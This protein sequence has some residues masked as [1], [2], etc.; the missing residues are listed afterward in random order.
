MSFNHQT[1]AIRSLFKKNSISKFRNP[2]SAAIYVI[3]N[4]C[5]LFVTYKRLA[6]DLGMDLFGI[7]AL[8][9]TLNVSFS[10]FLTGFNGSLI[11]F[12]PEFESKNNVS[13]VNRF[14]TTTVWSVI[15]I[16]TIIL[17]A[18][19][20]LPEHII[21]ILFAKEYYGVIQSSFPLI[22][23]YIWA[24][25]IC[26]VFLS[27]CEGFNKVYIKNI[28]LSI[29]AI[30]IL[31]Q[32]L[33]C[34]T[35]IDFPTTVSIFLVSS[36]FAAFLG[37]TSFFIF[38][39]IKFSQLF[40]WNFD[41]L[42]PTLKYHAHYFA[43]NVFG[44][45]QEP[46]NKLLIIHF[47]GAGAAGVYEM[48][49]KFVVQAR[50]VL[51]SATMALVPKIARMYIEVPVAI[52]GY[53]VKLFKLNLIISSITFPILGFSLPLLSYFWIGHVD[54]AFINIGLILIAGWYVNNLCLPAYAINIATNGIRL[55]TIASIITVSV[56][57]FVA[58]LLNAL[59]LGE[60][61][62]YAWAIAIAAGGLFLVLMREVHSAKE[63][64]KIVEFYDTFMVI[65]P[66]ALLYIFYLFDNF[67]IWVVLLSLLSLILFFAALYGNKY[68]RLLTS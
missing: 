12:L 13:N 52:Q 3:I 11:K 4:S 51:V 66:I 49:S 41:V 30:L 60:H 46:I 33:S 58:L 37:I 32:V 29:Q 56:N 25:N 19:H 15:F 31:A 55:N 18:I 38:A 54:H 20:F 35:P 45:L 36:V 47:A 68:L 27:V 50:T 40:Y 26:T 44:L 43:G 42:R 23:L 2:I 24:T 5:S 48:A 8:F 14:L 16:T 57:I 22:L 65:I 53:Y 17:V 34:K 64:E 59:K 21:T 6:S 67:E 1:S 63:N 61:I 9:I 7:W 39:K 62:I 28:I 10:L